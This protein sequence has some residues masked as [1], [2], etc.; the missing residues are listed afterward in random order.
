MA[1]HDVEA[2]RLEH[3]AAF[4]VVVRKVFLGYVERNFL[5]LAGLEQHAAEALK[6]LDGAR[7]GCHGVAHVELHHLVSVPLARVGNRYRRLEL[8][9]RACNRRL[10][11][12]EGG[13]GKSVAEG[14]EGVVHVVEPVGG[15]LTEVLRAL[16]HGA[17]RVQVVVIHG[18]LARGARKGHGQP[19]ARGYVAEHHVA[20]SVGGFASAEPDVENRVYVILLPCEHSRAAR[21]VEHHHGLAQFDKLGEQLTLHVGQAQVGAAGA[22]ARHV[23]ALAH[24]AYY[25]VGLGGHPKG[26]GLK[27]SVVAARYRLAELGGAL[28]HGVGHEVAPLGVQQLGLAGQGAL[29]SLLKR[30]VAVGRVGHAPCAGHVGARVGQGAYEGYLALLLERQQAFPVLEQHEGLGGYAA[31]RGAVFGGEDVGLGPLNVA[32][33]VRVLEKP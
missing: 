14:I 28:A 23:G 11:V 18:Q 30:R 26:L 21:E 20:Y 2:A 10:A 31:R 22:F 7:N 33:L 4:G 12:S 16:G 6:L 29:E 13:V 17:A 5:A 25:H 1:E 15:I 8:A 32:V 24:C 3:R 27:G 9:A 19:S